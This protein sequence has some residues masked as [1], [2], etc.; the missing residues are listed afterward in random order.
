MLKQTKIEEY[1]K[2]NPCKYVE[3][4]AKEECKSMSHLEKM[5]QD[6]VDKGGE[7]VILRD[8]ASP[9]QAGRSPGY[10]KHKVNFFF[11]SFLAK[12]C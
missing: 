1:F 2:K 11:F 5:F 10:L 7:G 9:Y 8:P 3:V 6:I 12:F 4:A